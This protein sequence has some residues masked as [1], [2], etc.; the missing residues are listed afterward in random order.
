MV[1]RI[2][3]HELT[4]GCLPKALCP[5]S[6][7]SGHRALKRWAG[8]HPCGTNTLGSDTTKT[9]AKH[10]GW[11]VNA[12]SN[13]QQPALIDTTSRWP[14]KAARL[15]LFLKHSGK[16]M[17]VT[18]SKSYK[19][20]KRDSPFWGKAWGALSWLSE[21][22]EQKDRSHAGKL[23]CLGCI[24]FWGPASFF[25]L[26]AAPYRVGSGVHFC[27]LNFPVALYTNLYHIMLPHLQ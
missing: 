11:G 12:P 5:L 20:G 25:I 21:H 19:A 17:W 9:L 18:Y 2:L 1:K 26:K 7:C 8:A 15:E 22:S 4:Q 14:Q 16:W 3:L 10:W 27:T 13:P 24:P 23:R 6:P